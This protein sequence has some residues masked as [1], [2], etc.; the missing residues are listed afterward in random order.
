MAGLLNISE[1]NASSPT[2]TFNNKNNSHSGLNNDFLNNLTMDATT[3][4][5][6]MTRKHNREEIAELFDLPL[7]DLLLQAQTIHRAHFT[8]NEVQISTLLSIKTGCLRRSPSFFPTMRATAS[9]P[10]PAANGTTS[11]TGAEG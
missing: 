8:A 9:V 4:S 6:Q 2:D 1:P 7:M 5:Q 11:V 3:A 10:L